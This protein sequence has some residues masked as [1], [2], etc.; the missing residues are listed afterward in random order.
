MTRDDNESVR[1]LERALAFMRNF[2]DD[3]WHTAYLIAQHNM[4]QHEEGSREHGDWAAIRDLIVIA[5]HGAPHTISYLD[6]DWDALIGGANRS[7]R[8]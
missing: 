2:G 3:G 4:L 8:G 5:S 1:R 7:R 6:E